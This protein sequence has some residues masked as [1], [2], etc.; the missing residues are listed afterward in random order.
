MEIL[1]SINSE[2]PDLLGGE[3]HVSLL[4]NSDDLFKSSLHIQHMKPHFAVRILVEGRS[5]P[6]LNTLLSQVQVL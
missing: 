6:P 1:I 5:S 2:K 4:E 3:K